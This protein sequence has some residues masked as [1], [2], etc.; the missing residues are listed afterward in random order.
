MKTQAIEKSDY[1]MLKSC[2][3]YDEL[4]GR[5]YNRIVEKYGI[6]TVNK[7][8]KELQATYDIKRNTYTD[9]DGLTYNT[10]IPR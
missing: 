5:Y 2:Y 8:V 6:D 1:E 10:L 9:S 4:D 3:C 7:I